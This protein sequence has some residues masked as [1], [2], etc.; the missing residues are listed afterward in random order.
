MGFLMKSDRIV[1]AL[2]VFLAIAAGCSGLRLPD[3]LIVSERD[4]P[5]PGKSE[6]RTGATPEVVIPPLTLQWTQDI[7]G[8]IGNGSPLVIDSIILVANL[9]GELYAIHAHTGK[10]LGW[11]DI[12]EAIQGTPAIDGNTAIVAAS[13]T[14]ESL[15]A[16]DLSSGKIQWRQPYGDLEVSPLLYQ[17]RIYVGNTAGVFFAVDRGTGEE[18]W[19]FEIPDNTRLKGIRSS[20]AIFGGMVIFGAEDGAVYA[21]DA[22]SGALRWRSETDGSIVSTPCVDDETVFI[23]NLAGTLWAID[24]TSGSPRWKTPAGSSIYA[25][26]SSARGLVYVGTTKG[27]MLAI[28]DATGATSW[29][30]DLGSVINSA[31]VISGSVLYVGTLKKFLYA[32]DA[33]S[34]GILMKQEM[35]GRVK[36]S[37]AVARGR[38]VVAT[39]ER[40]ILSFKGVDQ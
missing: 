31:P 17:Q 25:S 29:K 32:L 8:G 27:M 36:T 4:W 22:T 26:P 34:G 1:P 24:A 20:A 19:K 13:N 35:P 21:L 11:I 2:V 23:G 7:T 12:A 15:I 18:I 30:A 40:L 9:R 39:D 10:R 5:M 3:A 16:F 6:S 37:P 28:H 33:A 14:R 38:V